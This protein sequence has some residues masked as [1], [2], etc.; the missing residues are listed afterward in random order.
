[1]NLTCNSQ[2]LA[3]ELRLLNKIVPTKPAIQILSHVLLE[4]DGGGFSLYATDL[5]LGLLTTCP[6]RVHEP[7]RAA[8]P[9]A[10][11]LALVEQ[12]PDSDVSIA[13]LGQFIVIQCGAFKSKLQTSDA[14]DFPDRAV[15]DGLTNTLDADALRQLIASTRYAVASTSNK[16]VLRGALLT[17]SGPV[18][19]M[20]ATDSKRLV[21]ATRPRVGDDAKA[22]IPSKTLDALTNQGNVGDIEFTVGAKHLFFRANGRLLIS[23]MVE[24]EF[25]KYERVIPQSNDKV[26]TVDKDTLAAAL[27]RVSVVASEENNPVFFQI[28][29]G[30]V[31]LSASAVDV[32][33]ADEKIAVEY[34]GPPLKVCANGNYLLD[35]LSAAQGQVITLALKDAKTAMLLTDGSDHVAVVMLLK[36]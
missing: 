35:F 4:A 17:L 7:G 11:L 21:L 18:A 6:A 23:R 31:E 20:V 33:S 14:D 34:E 13:V 8:L 19:A 10:K 16:Y 27:R 24:G 22:I 12:F 5:E 1:M 32:G 28:S 26:I 15:P 30:N 36:L 2:R 29:P 3:A 9:V 25:P